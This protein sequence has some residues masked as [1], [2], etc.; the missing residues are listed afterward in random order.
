MSN[1]SISACFPEN[2]VTHEKMNAVLQNI[3]DEL[4]AEEPL[5]EDVGKQGKDI[6]EDSVW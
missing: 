3:I 6:D 5:S 1:S 2:S 4:P